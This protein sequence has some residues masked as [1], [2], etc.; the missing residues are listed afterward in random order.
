MAPR[1]FT[2]IPSQPAPRHKSVGDISQKLT[3]DPNISSFEMRVNKRTGI[4]QV[5]ARH[6]NGRTV[7]YE[8]SAPGLKQTIHFDPNSVTIEERDEAVIYLLS[9]GYS[10]MEVARL[11]GISQSRV[12]QIYR[13]RCLSR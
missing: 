4:L 10:Q 13:H 12:S 5:N 9:E 7:H 11:L 1:P 6:I 8:E 2:P 3:N